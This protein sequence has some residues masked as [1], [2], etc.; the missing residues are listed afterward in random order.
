MLKKEIT[1]TSSHMFDSV[2]S[3][4]DSVFRNAGNMAANIAGNE[5]VSKILKSDSTSGTDFVWSRYSLQKDMESLCSAYTYVSDM[6]VYFVKLDC[7]VSLATNTDAENRDRKFDPYKNFDGSL[8]DFKEYMRTPLYRKVVANKSGN[9]VVQQSFPIDTKGNASAMV[10]IELKKENIQNIF[11]A[12]N[13]QEDKNFYILDEF[14]TELFSSSHTDESKKICESIKDSANGAFT[15]KVDEEKY[16]LRSGKSTIKGLRYAYTTKEGN[17][18]QPL[19]QLTLILV[20]GFLILILLGVGLAIYFSHLHYVPIKSILNKLKKIDKNDSLENID[21]LKYIDSSFSD[22]MKNLSESEKTT[23]NLIFQNAC[24]KLLLSNN[25]NRSL[26]KLMNQYNKRFSYD[27]Y[28]LNFIVINEI[29][30]YYGDIDEESED[31]LNLIRFS[32][33]NI[34]N[35]L[36]GES[37]SGVSIIIEDDTICYIVGGNDRTEETLIPDIKDVFEKVV[38]ILQKNLGIFVSV[39]VSKSY[40]NIDETAAIFTQIKDIP[41]NITEQ[42]VVLFREETEDYETSLNLLE[43]KS[44]SDEYGLAEKISQYIQENYAQ[45]DLNVN[46]LGEKFYLSPSYLSKIF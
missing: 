27:I 22:L 12:K 44:V 23:Q 8:E 4:L 36:I 28:N 30:D 15:I 6:A 21:E 24:R 13:S 42:E 35:E 20:F 43:T 25:P 19:K 9:L 1:V 45:L 2:Q 17:F 3:S 41:N 38:S 11:D 18:W 33:A 37:L 40:T 26:K 5:N 7:L 31:E 34:I 16:V 32:I 14:G 46:L 29:S 39:V 10:M